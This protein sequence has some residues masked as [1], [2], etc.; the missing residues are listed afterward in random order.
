MSEGTA[1]VL[2]VTPNYTGART[3]TILVGMGDV[4]GAIAARAAAK[5]AQD[6]ASDALASE[7]AAEADRVQTGLDRTQTGL[8]RVQTGLDRT[9]TAA[10][11]VQTGLDRIATGQD[12][13]QTGL[14]RVATAADRVQTG[15]DATAAADSAAAA[16]ASQIDI[17]TNWQDKLDAADE[18]ATTATTQAGIAVTAANA[19]AVNTVADLR[20]LPSPASVKSANTLGCTAAGDEGGGLWRWVAGS[21]ATDN[22][23]TVVASSVDSSGRWL[24]VSTDEVWVKW[25]GAKGDGVTDDAAAIQAAIDYVIDQML[26]NNKLVPVYLNPGRYS[27]SSTLKLYRRRLVNGSIVYRVNNQNY[28]VQASWWNF[29]FITVNFGTPS[30]GYRAGQR[31]EIKPTF[32]DGPAIAIYGGRNMRL[33][34][35]SIVGQARPALTYIDPNTPNF[36]RCDTEWWNPNGAQDVP[37]APHCGIAIDPFCRLPPPRVYF[38]EDASTPPTATSGYAPLRDDLWYIGNASTGPFELRQLDASGNWVTLRTNLPLKTAI[39]T[40]DGTI[41]PGPTETSIAYG[42]IYFYPYNG[43]N[44]YWDG[45]LLR[46]STNTYSNTHHYYAFRNGGH[47]VSL[48]DQYD[49]RSRPGTTGVFMDRIEAQGFIVGVA[50]STSLGEGSADA[51]FPGEAGLGTQVGDSIILRDCNL[52]YNKVSLAVGQ[53]QNR[54]VTLEDV[55]AKSI[56]RLIDCTGYGQGT[57]P[58]PEVRGGVVVGVREFMSVSPGWGN[59]ASITGMY[60]EGVTS[61][62]VWGGGTAQQ[63]P[64]VVNG[65]TFKFMGEVYTTLSMDHHFRSDALVTF[66]GCYMAHYVAREIPLSFVNQGN[67]TFIGCLFDSPPMLLKPNLAV[68]ENCSI[69]W[70]GGSKDSLRKK[71]LGQSGFDDLATLGGTGKQVQGAPRFE[72]E[73]IGTE[74]YF[75]YRS[76]FGYRQILVNGASP[77]TVTVTNTLDGAG[78]KTGRATFSLPYGTARQRLRDPTNLL[79]RDFL[80]SNTNWYGENSTLSMAGCYMGRVESVTVSADPQV[81]DTVTLTNVP[82]SFPDGTHQLAILYLPEIRKRT[83]GTTTN[84]SNVITSVTASHGW[85]VGSRI[86]GTGIPAGAY[87]TAV[88]AT[89]LTISMNATAGGVTELHDAKFALEAEASDISWNTYLSKVWIKGDYIRNRVPTKDASNM[90]KIGWV[91]TASGAPGTWEPVYM[92]AVSP[93][94]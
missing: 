44:Y 82:L 63:M 74:F 5:V 57:G 52:S 9:A 11:R 33:F 40:Q 46:K 2:V 67:L 61:M 83:I 38:T 80:I 49:N 31:T 68:F 41:A 39:Y 35:F 86:A 62:G 29:S 88:A 37:Y 54:G 13:V 93:A 70:K 59:G 69:M 60:A 50:V 77:F 10:D 81:P 78:K 21:T 89:E 24:R 28:N 72:I 90:L 45:H 36:T 53:S 51:A 23:G 34:N 91:C 4:G 18:A 55:H 84:N 73:E 48:H 8:D 85:N 27:I 58:L 12:R 30:F 3:E 76:V 15:L 26:V 22:T 94:T 25:F 87:V 43:V 65:S 42:D 32:K 1:G 14:D 66:N 6:A 71:Y 19:H 16:L 64:L 7:V 79:T 47:Y 20:E 17:Q 92:S 56:N 75:R